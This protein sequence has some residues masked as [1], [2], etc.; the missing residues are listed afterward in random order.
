MRVKAKCNVRDANGW[1]TAGSV[2]ETEMDF[3]DAV[4]VLDA[5]KAAKPKAKEIVPEAPKEEPKTET[6][7]AEAEPA[8]RPRTSARRKKVSE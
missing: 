6:P 7:A 8:P 4:E 5:P 2:F 3:G 1:H